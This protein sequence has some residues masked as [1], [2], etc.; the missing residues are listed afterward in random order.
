MNALRDRLI[1][2]RR[3]VSL[4]EC[5]VNPAEVIGAVLLLLAF[6]FM[7]IFHV[8]LKL[9]QLE[10]HV[11]FVLKHLLLQPDGFVVIVNKLDLLRDSVV[12]IGI[13]KARVDLELKTLGVH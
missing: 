12:G 3:P 10:L 11:V 1:N 4:L 5:L 13:V 2:R 6:R 9:D 7:L 8:H